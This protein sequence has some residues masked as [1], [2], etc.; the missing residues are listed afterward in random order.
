M[1]T[2]YFPDIKT[3]PGNIG[4]TAFWHCF[5]GYKPPHH[6]AKT[7]GGRVARLRPQDYLLVEGSQFEFG[8]TYPVFQGQVTHLEDVDGL[9]VYH[10][11]IKNVEIMDIFGGQ[12]NLL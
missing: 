6:I 2:N 1:Q 8:K 12:P 5:P 11:D 7:I 3:K 4:V 9:Q 10:G